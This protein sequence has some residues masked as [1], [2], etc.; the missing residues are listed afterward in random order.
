MEM[1]TIGLLCAHPEPRMPAAV[2]IRTLKP[3]DDL[4]AC[5]GLLARVL[6]T[7]DPELLA[8]DLPA[9]EMHAV[10]LAG[11]TMGPGLE[12]LAA[13]YSLTPVGTARLR[14]DP[15]QSAHAPG[16]YREP[17]ILAFDLLAV[18][19]SMRGM[20]VGAALLD[21]LEDRART[22]GGAELACDL[23]ET[24][25]ESIEALTRRGFR[26]VDRIQLG[27]SDRLVLSRTLD[28]AAH[29]AA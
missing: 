25:T 8:R 23:P 9:E 15:G 4:V 17:G 28:P 16:W 21:A 26:A 10:R 5:A 27:D 24:A 20:G 3:G 1:F 2:T 12:L 14:T 19:P 22:L 29:A 13:E 18:E 11:L 6:Q 7:T